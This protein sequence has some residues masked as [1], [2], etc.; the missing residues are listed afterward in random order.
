LLSSGETTS[1]EAGSYKAAAQLPVVLLA[2][3]AGACLT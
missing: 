2:F 3:P 1:K